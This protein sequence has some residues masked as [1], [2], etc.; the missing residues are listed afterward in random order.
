MSEQIVLSTQQKD[1]ARRA[2]K[3]FDKKGQDKISTKDLGQL[4]HSCA[5]TVTSEKLEELVDTIDDGGSGYIDF[6]QFCVLYGRK[7]KEDDDEKELREAFRILD[8]DNQGVIPVD[9]L[10]WILRELGDDITEEEIDDMV[11]MTDVDGSG[12]VDY[13]EFRALMNG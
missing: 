5:M 11:A 13:E 4:F 10:R 12:T 1:D 3:L 7:K 6:D 9:D 2:F 8:K